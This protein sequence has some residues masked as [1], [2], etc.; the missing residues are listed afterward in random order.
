MIGGA[1]PEEAAASYDR[2]QLGGDRRSAVIEREVVVL[3]QANL[4]RHRYRNTA[5]L[6]VIAAS[7]IG[8]FLM[9][10]EAIQVSA[11]TCAAP[12]SR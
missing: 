11:P 4:K 10:T 3:K 8:A 12:R 1:T 6:I 7:C 2:I 9:G 5:L